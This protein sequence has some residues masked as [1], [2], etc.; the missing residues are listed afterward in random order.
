MAEV[1]LTQKSF[2]EKDGM[3]KVWIA[4]RFSTV[5]YIPMR[6]RGLEIQFKMVVLSAEGDEK[7]RGLSQLS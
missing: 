5:A 2:F 3:A 7:K 4:P 1:N 6:S